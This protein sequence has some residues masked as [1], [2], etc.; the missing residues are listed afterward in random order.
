[1]KFN[2]VYDKYKNII[3]ESFT[4]KTV[5]K[6]SS[7]L[8]DKSND[9]M[10][11]RK[12]IFDKLKEYL[13]EDGE[14]Y[15]GDYKTDLPGFIYK[16]KEE[17]GEIKSY[18]E[19]D[20]TLHTTKVDGMYT[21]SVI[22]LPENEWYITLNFVDDDYVYDFEE[23]WENLEDYEKNQIL[24][25]FGFEDDDLYINE[26]FT[27]RISKT[28]NKSLTDR[29][30]SIMRKVLITTFNGNKT[31]EMECPNG[32]VTKE[33][34]QE[35]YKNNI[36]D[37]HNNVQ[38][39]ELLGIGEVGDSAFSC[40]TE[41]TEVI[42]HEG[43]KRIGQESF[44]SCKFTEI[45][46]PKSLEII[47]R[48]AFLY[49]KLEFVEVPD[50]VKFIGARAF[51]TKS[52]KELVIGNHN[53]HIGRNVVN[54]S[55]DIVFKNYNPNQEDT[56]D[57]NTQIEFED[58]AVEELI[59]DNFIEQDEPFTINDAIEIG[60]EKDEYGTVDRD[61]PLNE[62]DDSYWKDNEDIVKFNE[63][64]YFQEI[65]SIPEYCFA[66]CISLEE[67]SLPHKVRVIEESAFV[68]CLSLKSVNISKSGMLKIIGESAFANTGFENLVIPEG[69]TQIEDYAFSDC[70]NLKSVVL[71]STI[72]SIGKCAFSNCSSLSEVKGLE[73][74][75][76]FGEDVFWECSNL[77]SKLEDK[78]KPTVYKERNIL[79]FSYYDDYDNIEEEAVASY[80]LNHY[81]TD[82]VDELKDN[83]D[84]M[85][86]EM[87]P[88]SENFDESSF[89]EY[90][91][92]HMNMIC[93]DDWDMFKSSLKDD[94]N[95]WVSV[96]DEETFNDIESA[97]DYCI[98]D[99]TEWSDITVKTEDGGLN[100]NGTLIYPMS[101]RS[102]IN[103]DIE[104]YIPN[105]YIDYNSRR[106][107]DRQNFK[108][109]Y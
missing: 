16:E 72:Q 52:L 18:H 104:S 57:L 17:D 69:V 105:D 100:V 32:I 47:D 77:I 42:L 102:M 67:I 2:E 88:E 11:R 61:F 9:V 21:Y 109:E 106:F 85:E 43:L 81:D 25:Y 40:M 108:I 103:D 54:S 50:T 20:I 44:Q 48:G 60:K 37:I 14:F 4:K 22:E 95:S 94:R 38:R 13:Y 96:E 1:M 76:D 97:I 58:K 15:E 55:T 86:D 87:N 53:I 49:S 45:H 107:S 12:R 7:D 29:A 30:D 3:S 10:F 74:V 28:G 63:L 68:N 92:Y 71:P 80:I 46:F 64:R 70:R 59:Y 79:D 101:D 24:R 98:P 33:Q 23:D 26:S 27:K 65:V 93:Q 35:F 19:V 91:Y 31:L 6:S 39:V 62:L 78:F 66:N 89:Q 90:A 34:S 51:D 56:F 75:K 83:E 8:I 99:G 41:M 84:W 5:K 36:E 82:D 73:Y